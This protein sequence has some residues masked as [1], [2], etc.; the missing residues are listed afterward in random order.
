MSNYKKCLNYLKDPILVARF[1]KYFGIVRCHHQDENVALSHTVN[2]ELNG[3]SSL[4]ENRDGS[5]YQ[6]TNK[7]W[8]YLFFFGTYLGDEIGYSII[9][10]F[11]IWNVD[12]AIARK[13]VLVWAVVMYIGQSIKDIVR[14]PRPACPPVVRLQNKWSVEY[15]M[16]STHAVV[17]ITLPFSVL[18][19]L[20]NKYQIDYAVGISLALLWCTLITLSRLYLGMHTVL[21][22]MAGL[23]L[24][25]VLLIP[26][27]PVADIADRFLMYC[28]WTPF[29][30]VTLTV[31]LIIMYPTGNQWTPTKGDTSQILGTCA[32][33][34][35]GGWLL[36]MLGLQNENIIMNPMNNN[37]SWPS[38]KELGNIVIRSGLGYICIVVFLLIVKYAFDGLDVLLSIC[39]IKVMDDKLNRRVAILDNAYKYLSIYLVS[40]VIIF[41]IPLLQQTLGVGRQSFYN[42]AK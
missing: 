29:I 16:P 36:V 24:A 38:L 17:S 9:I 39:G 10:P 35:S 15:G 34:L 1:Q 20:S 12:S 21:D 37:I 4:A 27:L 22:V 2:N 19:Y 40:F 6:I 18:Y 14:W 8:F 7:F 32:G 42:E 11:F 13:I 3:N 25:I 31:G 5:N 28:F 26:I 30:L 23:S 33:I 41:G